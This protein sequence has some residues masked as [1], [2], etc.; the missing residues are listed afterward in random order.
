MWAEGCGKIENGWLCAEKLIY[1][2]N[3]MSYNTYWLNSDTIIAEQP[4]GLNSNF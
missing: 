2:E 4:E 3:E 1:L